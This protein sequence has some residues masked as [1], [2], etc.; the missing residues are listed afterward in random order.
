MASAKSAASRSDLSKWKPLPAQKQAPVSL[1]G[2]LQVKQ[3]AESSLQFS[4]S[5]LNLPNETEGQRLRAYRCWTT[6]LR[7][8]G[9]GPAGPTDI[10]SVVTTKHGRNNLGA[11]GFEPAT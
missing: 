1:T 11:T 5:L 8:C 10:L 9:L 3:I 4:L 6:M 2:K 7:Q